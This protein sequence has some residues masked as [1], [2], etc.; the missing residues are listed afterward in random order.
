MNT[1]QLLLKNGIK[2]ILFENE[3][4]FKSNVVQTLAIKL[5]DSI[6]ETRSEM[7]RNLFSE[8][9]L[10]K[11][12]PHIEYFVSFLEAFHPG[13]FTF[14]DGSILNITEENVKDIKELFEQLN[15]ESRQ[16]MASEIFENAQTFKQHIDFSKKAKELL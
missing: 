5:N 14:Q 7:Q 12:S 11:K 4:N 13:K 15:P 2:S 3:E 10:T 6:N 16:K 8:E 1:T 9:H